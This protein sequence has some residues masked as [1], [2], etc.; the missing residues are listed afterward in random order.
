MKY[1]LMRE[2]I[3]WKKQ[4]FIDLVTAIALPLISVLIYSGLSNYTIQ[5]MEWLYSMPGDLHNFLGIKRRV[6]A[7]NV[8]FYLVAAYSIEV[9]VITWRSCVRVVDSFWTDEWN[10]SIFFICGQMYS[11]SMIYAAKL[12]CAVAGVISTYICMG[13]TISICISNDMGKHT[14]SVNAADLWPRF[15]LAVVVTIMLVSI[16]ALY[17]AR[18]HANMEAGGVW[19]AEVLLLGSLILGNIYKFVNAFNVLLSINGKDSGGIDRLT[20]GLKGLYMMSPL[21]WCNVNPGKPVGS[22]MVQLVICT[23]IICITSFFGILGYRKRRFV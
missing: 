20:E 9:F 13:I 5:A 22:L 17:A 8:T 6:N 14:Q 12:I 21:S 19:L 3:R 23:V 16:M 11:R 10:G 4:F 2:F 7:D 1:L 15:G 18:A